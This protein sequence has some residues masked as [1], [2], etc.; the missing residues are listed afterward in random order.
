MARA[1]GIDYNT[2]RVTVGD[3]EEDTIHRHADREGLSINDAMADVVEQ[4]LAELNLS[5][6]REE[7]ESRGVVSFDAE[8]LSLL[9]SWPKVGP[10]TALDDEDKAF[11]TMMINVVASTVLTQIITAKVKKGIANVMERKDEGDGTS[12]SPFPVN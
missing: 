10:M 4:K 3:S 11:V 6:A 5:F 9:V 7:D 1:E 2:Y 12:K 8:Q